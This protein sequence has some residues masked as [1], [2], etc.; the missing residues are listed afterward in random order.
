MMP[1]DSPAPAAQV[2]SVPAPAHHVCIV[3]D[4]IDAD[5][6]ARICAAARAERMRHA[7][8]RVI[9]QISPPG[10]YPSNWTLGALGELIRI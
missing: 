9:V 4:G 8:A 3:L 10:E 7:G 5:S 2:A 6:V 1:T